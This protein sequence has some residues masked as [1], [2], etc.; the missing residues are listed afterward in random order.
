MSI[1]KHPGL[2]KP[3]TF[4][5]IK[6]DAC[7]LKDSWPQWKKDDYPD[8]LTELCFN[9]CDKEGELIDLEC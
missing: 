2:Y 4:L 3:G 6:S 5:K 7:D 1:S 8:G 9:L